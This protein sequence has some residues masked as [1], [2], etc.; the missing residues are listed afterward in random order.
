MGGPEY[1]VGN[2]RLGARYNP[3]FSRLH[4]QDANVQ[5]NSRTVF[6]PNNNIYIRIGVCLGSNCG[7]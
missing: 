3:T 4:E 7:Q 5:H 2:A 1:R 6:L